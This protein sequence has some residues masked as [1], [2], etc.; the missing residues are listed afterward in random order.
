[1]IAQLLGFNMGLL[2]TH[3]YTNTFVDFN[4]DLVFHGS[5]QERSM[6]SK[7]RCGCPYKSQE[8]SQF[9]Q[10]QMMHYMYKKY[11]DELWWYWWTCY[12]AKL[13]V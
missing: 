5:I 1:M 4:E 12:F 2:S 7:Q 10:K 8:L 9:T 11:S 13:Q 3:V 6:I